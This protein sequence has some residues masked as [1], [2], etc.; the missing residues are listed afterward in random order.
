MIDPYSIA[1]SEKSYEDLFLLMLQY[2]YANGI[3]S[4]SEDFLDYVSLEDDLENSLII[5]FSVYAFILSETY[6]DLTRIYKSTNLWEASDT[7]LDIIG[8]MFLTRRQE[9]YAVAEVTYS[10]A[11][12]NLVNVII[13]KGSMVS[14]N[15]EDTL[16]FTTLE[17]VILPAGSLSINAGVQCTTSGPSGNLGPNTLT[18]IV[19]SI[20][21]IEE[22]TNTLKATGGRD[23]ESKVDYRN[24]LLNWKYILAKGTYNAVVDSI[25]EVSAV[26][27]YYI[28]RYWDG[29]G[30]TKII[31]DPPTEVVLDLV[32]AS[33]DTSKAVDE[34]FWVV[35]VESLN[36][37]VNMIVNVSLDSTIAIS[38]TRLNEIEMLA[39]SLVKIYIDGGN[40]LDGTKREALGIGNDF[41][42]FRCGIYLSEQISEIKDIT[43]ISPSI[44]VTIESHE[45]AVCGS[46]NITVV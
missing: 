27:G 44:P 46:V 24:R 33:L 18:E 8:Q 20:E 39:E 21:G 11:T 2:A 9:T 7:D 14:S 35:G 26:E 23:A 6:V 31:I 12:P 22:V 41:V 3:L 34:D 29:Y 17:E 38:Q 13:P 36:I 25:D 42:P 40:N 19:G 4:N 5:Y 16:Y 30:S 15:T 43:F 45:K 32:K 28:E 10:T 1:Y 37:S